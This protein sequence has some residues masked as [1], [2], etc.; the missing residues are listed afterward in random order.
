[1]NI[2][3]PLE[4]APG[5]LTGEVPPGQLPSRHTAHPGSDGFSVSLQCCYIMASPQDTEGNKNQSVEVI[6]ESDDKENSPPDRGPTPTRDEASS[7][8]NS[9]PCG[10]SKYKFVRNKKLFCSFFHHTRH[11]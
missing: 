5:N 8:G 1:M 11:H 3:T 6:E 9:L 4:T 2:V 7:E 10:V